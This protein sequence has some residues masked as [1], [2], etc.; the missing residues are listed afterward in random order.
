MVHLICLRCNRAN[1]SDARF[2]SQCGAGLLR[3]FC[4]EC[5]VIND[6]ESHFCMSCGAALSMQPPLPAAAPVSVPSDVPE[7]T[8]VAIAGPDETPLQSPPAEQAH[9]VD[10]APS[11]P[12]I[13]AV[14]VPA[15]PHRSRQVAR[16]P[17]LFGFGGTTAMLLAAA[18][19]WRPTPTNAPAVDTDTPAAV[20]TVSPMAHAATAVPAA[21]AAQAAP[22]PAAALPPTDT[23]P[24]DA[25]VP[26]ATRAVA[27]EGNRPPARD[28]SAMLAARP[29]AAGPPRRAPEP[30]MPDRPAAPARAAPAPACTPQ[31]DA[32][33][34]CAPG[35][36]VTGR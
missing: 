16:A 12:L 8:D 3:R 14:A 30:R 29:P 13:A 36:T 24:T 33:G 32:L 28:A 34:L 35:T 22:A 23:R 1:P 11:L 5:H 7:L 31:V 2:C 17:L 18:L 20:A 9:T 15:A 6:A 25:M 4:S 21:S 10:D 26:T 27:K 19:W